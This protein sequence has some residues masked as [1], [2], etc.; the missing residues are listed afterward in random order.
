[1][2]PHLWPPTLVLT[3]QKK[4]TMVAMVAASRELELNPNKV[5]GGGAGVVVVFVVVA[6][7]A[8]DM[9]IFSQF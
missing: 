9:K 8:L 7:G 4:R 5:G 6:W 2:D 3:G 1:M